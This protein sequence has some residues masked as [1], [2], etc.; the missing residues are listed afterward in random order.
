M[1]GRFVAFRPFIIVLMIFQIVTKY[2]FI[3]SL[4]LIACKGFILSLCYLLVLLTLG[5]YTCLLGLVCSLILISKTIELLNV[6]QSLSL[7]T[8]NIFFYF[9]Y[10]EYRHAFYPRKGKQRRKLWYIMTFHNLALFNTK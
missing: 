5:W 9:T 3:S 2:Y 1:G 6:T 8:Q 7:E 4:F 10:H